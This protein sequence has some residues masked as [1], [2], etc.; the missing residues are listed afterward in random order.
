MNEN[1]IIDTLDTLQS[2]YDW[3]GESKFLKLY[4]ETSGTDR[5]KLIE[6]IGETIKNCEKPIVLA[7]LINI[8]SSL[9]ISQVEPEIKE[10]QTK[11]IAQ[12]EPLKSVI[13]NFLIFRKL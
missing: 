11:Q 2:G 1:T 5:T 4:K 7:R 9:D 12:K 13:G 10:L 8:C 6:L 3:S